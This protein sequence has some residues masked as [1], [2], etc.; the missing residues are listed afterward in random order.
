MPTKT[1]DFNHAGAG[2]QTLA[3]DECG[4]STGDVNAHR[5]QTKWRGEE[6]E[7]ERTGRELGRPLS[8]REAEI[9]RHLRGTDDN[10]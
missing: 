7:K 1:D 6:R 9:I 3:V 2:D 10:E 4:G 5:N 8:P